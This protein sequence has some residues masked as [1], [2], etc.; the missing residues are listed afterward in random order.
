MLPSLWDLRAGESRRL[1]GFGDALDASYQ[2]RLAEL[3]FLPGAEVTCVIRPALGAPRV[4]RIQASVFSLDDV[5]AR[6]VFTEA[7]ATANGSD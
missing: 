5:V 2:E 4:F 7:A 6:Q 1:A 3:G